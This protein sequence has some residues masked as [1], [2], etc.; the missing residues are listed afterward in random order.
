MLVICLIFKLVNYQPKSSC[1]QVQKLLWDSNFL[2]NLSTNVGECSLNEENS[3]LFFIPQ[4]P[5]TKK[6]QLLSQASMPSFP[7]GTW[8][9]IMLPCR[10]GDP[11]GLTLH[12]FCRS[13]SL[14]PIY[15]S[16]IYL[17]TY[18]ISMYDQTTLQNPSFL[19]TLSYNCILQAS[20][21]HTRTVFP[22]LVLWTLLK[23]EC[24]CVAIYKD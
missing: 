12:W 4:T 1:C 6:Q 24:I 3:N 5:K 9:W 11:A 23:A 10:S 21:I 14:L 18:E 8:S 20:C 13:L 2:L 19:N 16:F 15:E 7:L 17:P 22:S